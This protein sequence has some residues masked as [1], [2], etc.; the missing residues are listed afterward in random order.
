MHNHYSNSWLNEFS[1]LPGACLEVMK[2]RN[3]KVCLGFL[4]RKTIVPHTYLTFTWHSKGEC[5]LVNSLNDLYLQLQLC[6]YINV[7]Y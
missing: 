6:N 5:S 1:Y 3:L 2:Y 4:N 7:G